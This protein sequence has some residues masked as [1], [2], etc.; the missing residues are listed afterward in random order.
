MYSTL[1]E[2]DVDPDS[3]VFHQGDGRPLASETPNRILR[4]ALKEA[5][6]QQVTFHAFR[7]SFVAAA[8]ASDIPI[9][10]PSTSSST[11]DNGATS[12]GRTCRIFSLAERAWVS[13]GL[14]D[15]SPH[16]VGLTCDVGGA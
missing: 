6:L 1:V 14:G 9:T 11:A 5:A 8:I 10:R 7:Q 4:R 12:P 15:N 2:A 16:P 13:G 3:F